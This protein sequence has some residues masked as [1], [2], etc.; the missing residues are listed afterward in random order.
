MITR[1]SQLNFLY[2][3]RSFSLAESK[4]HTCIQLLLDTLDK[5]EDLVDIFKLFHKQRSKRSSQMYSVSIEEL[6]IFLEDL[7]ISFDLDETTPI[8][9]NLSKDPKALSNSYI[10]SNSPGR[11]SGYSQAPKTFTFEHFLDFILPQSLFLNQQVYLK[12]LKNRLIKLYK[13]QLQGLRKYE[14][15]FTTQRR[16]VGESS[17][18]F[19]F[20]DKMF[21]L[22]LYNNEDIKAVMRKSSLVFTPTSRFDNG[23]KSAKRYNRMRTMSPH[24]KKDFQLDDDSPHSPISVAQRRALRSIPMPILESQNMSKSESK[25]V[26]GVQGSGLRIKPVL[27]GAGVESEAAQ[28]P[29]VPSGVQ[30]FSSSETPSI[31]GFGEALKENQS[32]DAEIGKQVHSSSSADVPSFVENEYTDYVLKQKDEARKQQKLTLE[33]I[34]LEDK[35]KNSENYASKKTGNKRQGGYSEQLESNQSSEL[36]PPSIEYAT[37]KRSS[38]AREEDTNTNKLAKKYKEDEEIE[39]NSSSR[40]LSM[41]FRQRRTS[42]ASKFPSKNQMNRRSSVTDA[43]Y[44]ITVTKSNADLPSSRIHKKRISMVRRRTGSTLNVD[45]EVR[46]WYSMAQNPIFELPSPNKYARRFKERMKEHVPK[47]KKKKEEEESPTG[48]GFNVKPV[49]PEIEEGSKES[50]VDESSHI[51]QTPSSKETESELDD[52]GNK[53]KDKKFL[54]D[55]SEE[56][57]RSFQEKVMQMNLKDYYNPFCNLFSITKPIVLTLLKKIFLQEIQNFRELKVRSNVVGSS[58]KF[59]KKLFLRFL[60]HEKNGFITSKDLRHFLVKVRNMKVHVEGEEMMLDYVFWRFGKQ[61]TNEVI[62][63]REL[64]KFFFGVYETNEADNQDEESSDE[65]AKPTG[66]EEQRSRHPA[67]MVSIEKH[68]RASTRYKSLLGKTGRSKAKKLKAGKRRKYYN[69]YYRRF[70]EGGEKERVERGG[71]FSR[72]IKIKQNR[73]GSLA[74]ETEIGRYVKAMGRVKER[75]IDRLED[76][77]SLVGGLGGGEVDITDLND[78]DSQLKRRVESMLTRYSEREN[79]QRRPILRTAPQYGGSKK[80]Q[81]GQRR[82]GGVRGRVAQAPTAR[83]VVK[84]AGTISIL[85]RTQELWRKTKTDRSKSA[86]STHL[87]KT[88][89]KES[90]SQTAKKQRI[91]KMGENMRKN[92]KTETK[93]AKTRVDQAVRRATA[94]KRRLKPKNQKME[95]SIASTFS[96][97]N[98]DSISSMLY[99][100]KRRRIKHHPTSGRNH[101]NGYTHYKS[102]TEHKNKSKQYN[103]LLSHSKG[104]VMSTTTVNTLYLTRPASKRLESTQR[105]PTKSSLRK[106]GDLVNLEDGKNQ[107]KNSNKFG[108]NHAVNKIYEKRRF[109]IGHIVRTK[110]YL[111]SIENLKLRFCDYLKFVIES[112]KELSRM[113]M[114]IPVMHNRELNALINLFFGKKNKVGIFMFRDILEGKLQIGVGERRKEANYAVCLIFERLNCLEVS[115]TQKLDFF[116]FFVERKHQRRQTGY[117]AQP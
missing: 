9:F 22:C 82:V 23:K 90:Q 75:S 53:S 69:F 17:K 61:S 95:F 49:D 41:A 2:L 44:S 72:R 52:A 101:S 20:N 31:G 68:Q 116:D 14:E 100:P 15:N 35:S 26:S 47:H 64:L 112:E 89:R 38:Q 54:E 87:S 10:K 103:R 37:F 21:E 30:G 84:K 28:S 98:Q 13:S 5:F 4:T 93:R 42:I 66:M 11:K 24:L 78:Y 7:Q 45:I 8:L 92:F 1:E 40:H 39:D 96:S 108:D 91:L 59:D 32:P 71:L 3:L 81:T 34:N 57:G 46:P 16:S 105:P 97:P 104:V 73:A 25:S 85:S 19:K 109:G 117:I 114:R 65:E 94:L 60:D 80:P 62:G 51:F 29:L 88:Y 111:K 56:L 43:P 74:E 67:S 58:A 48:F 99:I 36:N 18:Q 63:Y 27:I 6:K 106:T 55:E 115:K 107:R 12:N 50:Q 83:K 33:A 86:A 76:F 77:E 70:E 110:Q 79:M 102:R 113:R